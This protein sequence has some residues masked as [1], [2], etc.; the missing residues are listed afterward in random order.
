M[1]SGILIHPDELTNAWIDRM[2]N[3]G[4]DVLG[5]HPVGGKNAAE[6]LENLL[7]KLESRTFVPCWTVPPRAD[8]QLNMKCTPQAI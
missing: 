2:A 7:Q 1:K 5:I 6:S 3:A 4:I 8:S